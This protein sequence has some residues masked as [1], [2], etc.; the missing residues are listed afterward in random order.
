MGEQLA[1]RGQQGNGFLWL[2]KNGRGRLEHDKRPSSVPIQGKAGLLHRRHGALPEPI[3]SADGHFWAVLDGVISNRDALRA[4]LP[5]A[6][7][8]DAALVLAA[9]A[10]WG[11][12]APSHLHGTFA[13]AV[14]DL[15]AKHLLLARDASG[16]KPLYYSV[17]RNRLSFA[18]EIKALLVVPETRAKLERNSLAEYLRFGRPLDPGRTP[19]ANIYALL[20]GHRLVVS[21]EAPQKAKAE[22]FT[23]PDITLPEGDRAEA[24]HAML[25]SAVARHAAGDGAHGVCLT[26]G[27]GSTSTAMALRQHLGP[28][29]LLNSFSI[30]S[31]EPGFDERTWITLANGELHS[32]TNWFTPLGEDFIAELDVMLWHQEVPFAAPAVYGQWCAMRAAYDARVTLILDGYG[33]EQQFGAPAQQASLLQRF[34]ARHTDA[35]A[36]LLARL[37]PQLSFSGEQPDLLAPIVEAADRSAMAFG[38]E[39]RMPYLDQTIA[40]MAAQ[41]TPEERQDRQLLRRAMAPLVPEPILARPPVAPFHLPF[42][43]WMQQ[44][45][46]PAFMQDMK[47]ARTPIVPMVQSGRLREVLTRQ[48]EKYDPSCAPLLFR[49]FVANRWMLRFNIVSSM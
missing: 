1:H 48:I 47:H 28:E 25:L 13:L 26:G 16:L 34:W 18:S 37:A 2:Q 41:L 31:D 4:A 33:A 38:I 35:D 44:H 24:L 21:F 10:R 22:P 12:D 49:L 40:A 5:E 42:H 32:L 20:P 46:L 39:L 14:L 36:R 11:V 8:G 3:G 29:H 15:T 30:L 19:F 9:Y 7:E 23:P 17:L 27:L 45:V 6:G 43:A